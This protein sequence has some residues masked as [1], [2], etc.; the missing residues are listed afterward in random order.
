MS[1]IIDEASMVVLDD[2]EEE[3]ELLDAYEKGELIPVENQEGMRKKLRAAA[4]ASLE[5]TKH[6]SIRVSERDYRKIKA[7]SIES[8]ISYQAI[9][10]S[11]IHQYADGK[12]TIN[13]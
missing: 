12:I 9:I 5:K 8:G 7:R 6:I 1:N 2:R 4:K 3:K 11:L 10:G 13:V